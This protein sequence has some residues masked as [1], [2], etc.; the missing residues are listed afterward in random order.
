MEVLT[1]PPLRPHSAEQQS[2]GATLL[3]DC[4]SSKTHACAK[5][6]LESYASEVG[7][8]WWYG[9]ISGY[10]HVPPPSL[11]PDTAPSPLPTQGV[12]LDENAV[13]FQ[14]SKDLDSS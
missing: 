3:I 5:L 14:P 8:P 11:P 6:L 7:G 12:C 2:A 13:L 10:S 9:S 4:R 1:T